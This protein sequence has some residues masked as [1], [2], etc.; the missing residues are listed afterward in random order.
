MV[1][2]MGHYDMKPV[3][4]VILLLIWIAMIPTYVS[5]DHVDQV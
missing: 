4:L 3:L 2:Q 5:V 1:A